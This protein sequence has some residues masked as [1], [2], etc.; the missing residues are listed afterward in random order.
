MEKRPSVRKRMSSSKGFTGMSLLHKYL[1][2]LYEF[3]ILRDMV[4]D[5]FHTLPLNVVKSQLTYLLDNEIIHPEE[6]DEAL[7]NFP[8]TRELKAGRVPTP[9]GND[10]KGLSN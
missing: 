6:L 3:N 5:I 8:W 4:Y 9:I 1:F 2:P 7:R 10:L